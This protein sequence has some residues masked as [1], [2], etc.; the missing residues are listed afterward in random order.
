M[1]RN[2]KRGFILMLD[3]QRKEAGI[4]PLVAWG[5][6]ALITSVIGAAGYGAYQYTSWWSDTGLFLAEKTMGIMLALVNMFFG[7]SM[8]L[9]ETVASSSILQTPLTR[10]GSADA[11]AVQH[12]WSIVRDFSNMLVVLGFVVVGIATILRIREYEAQKRLVPLIIVAL[13]INFSM[14]ICGVIIDATN[15]TANYFTRISGPAG[16]TVPFQNVVQNPQLMD[17]IMKQI[18]G[19]PL[20]KDNFLQWVSAMASIILLTGIAAMIFFMYGMLLLFRRVALMCL[21]ILAPLAFVCYVFPA[22]KPIFNK[23]W[24]QFTQWAIITIPASFF[25]YLAGHMIQGYFGANSDL[26]VTGANLAFWIP[27]AFLFFA[28]SLI[29]Q[30]SALGASAAIGLVTGAAGFAMG[31]SK[32]VGGKVGGFAASAAG[33]TRAGQAVRNFGTRVGEGLG[34]V[35]KGTL[36]N[37]Q[38]AKQAEAK[39]RIDLLSNDRKAALAN[40]WAYTAE[41][42]ENKAAAIQSLVASGDSDRLTNREQAAAFVIGRGGGAKISDLAKQDY[43]FAT[44]AMRE[45][46]LETNWSSMSRNQRRGVDLTDINGDFAERVMS[47]GDISNYRV[48]PQASRDHMRTVVRPELVARQSA[49]TPPTAAVPATMTSP[50]IPASPGSREWQKTQDLINEID[51]LP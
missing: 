6:V 3:P 41:Q 30:S 11:A 42:R 16:I 24:S 13:L 8:G 21:V 29:F 35:S 22:T 12:G 47:R 14:L 43:R 25:I 18:G 2:I 4:A 20:T 23:W 37:R 49:Y 39:K 9:F 51:R 34:V 32:K 17:G 31:T 1:I 50:A 36:A 27:T 19:P 44:P 10:G 33:A 46:Q 45:Q 5:I 40:G 48:A 38:A 28:Y 26:N 7:L 15:I